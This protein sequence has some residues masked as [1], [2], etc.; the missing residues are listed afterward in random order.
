M[1]L[2]GVKKNAQLE[3]HD[4]EFSFFFGVKEHE[5]PETLLQRHSWEESEDYGGAQETVQVVVT[6]QC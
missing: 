2:V 1:T 3:S 4:E 5:G 6:E